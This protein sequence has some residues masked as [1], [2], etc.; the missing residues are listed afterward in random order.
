MTV[1]S[2]LQA[3]VPVLDD[4]TVETLSARILVEEHRLYPGGD[5]DSCSTEA[6][7]STAGGFAVR[8]RLSPKRA[9]DA[10]RLASKRQ[11]R[12]FRRAIDPDRH[13]D[14][15]DAAAHEQRRVVASRDAG[16]HRKLPRRNRADAGQH[17]LTAVR[18]SGQD[19]RDVRAPRLRSGVGDRAR[20][21]STG[22]VAPRDQRGDVGGASRPEADARELDSARSRSPA[23]V[24]ASCSTWMPRDVERRRHVVVVVV[25]AED[26]ED[27]VRRGERARALRPTAPTNCRSPQVT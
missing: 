7:E 17:D 20:A 22:P 27:A 3:A 24:R 21:E 19:Q 11:H 18:V 23:R 5:S 2:S 15:S 26:G 16:D 6:G 1:R 25:V 8:R 13:V 10:I 4:D 9:W 12:D 14:R